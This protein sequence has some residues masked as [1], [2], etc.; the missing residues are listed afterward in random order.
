MIIINAKC[1]N[2]LGGDAF[3]ET[4][5]SAGSAAEVMA[6]I[7]KVPRNET[8]ADQWQSQIF[9]RILMKYHVI[10]VSQMD[11][12]LIRNMHLIPAHSVEEAIRLADE[13]LQKTDGTI[14]VIPMGISCMI[15]R[16]ATEQA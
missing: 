1:E 11:Q 6:A 13:L 14:T 12:D 5:H 15:Q 4:F 9:A 2:G 8:V 10:L 3:Y 16:P 7:M